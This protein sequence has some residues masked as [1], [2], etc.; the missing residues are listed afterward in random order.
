MTDA[1]HV[2]TSGAHVTVFHLR[3]ILLAVC[4]SLWIGSVAAAEP[5][6]DPSVRLPSGTRKSPDGQLVSGRGL[7]D[8]TDVIA[9]DL[10]RRGIA[11][12]QV[13]PYKVRSVELT[14][15]I[16]LT[17]STGWIAIHVMRI[18]GKTAISF[19]PRSSPDPRP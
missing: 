7:R 19:V 3:V 6:V 2:E 17:A 14:R 12:R 8:S 11:V 16:S 1:N 18:A 4:L 10:A 9:K 15:F 5:Y 13:G